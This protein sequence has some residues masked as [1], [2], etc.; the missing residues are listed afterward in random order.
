MDQPFF[1]TIDWKALEKRQIEPP[2][3]PEVVSIFLK[4]SKNKKN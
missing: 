2:F 4:K 3:K 1:K